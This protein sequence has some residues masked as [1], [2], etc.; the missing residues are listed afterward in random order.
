[1]TVRKFGF[2]VAGTPRWHGS[3]VP[4]Q[5]RTPGVQDF[6]RT[7]SGKNCNVD[8]N[9]LFCGKLPAHSE[10]GRQCLW[11]KTYGDQHPLLWILLL[12]RGIGVLFVYWRVNYQKIFSQLQV[13]ESFAYRFL[14]D[15]S[16][17][18]KQMVAGCK[19][20]VIL[21]SNIIAKCE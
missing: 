12:T 16:V 18:S 1:M 20:F 11:L 3:S 5:T 2:L 17:S 13:V 6:S 7:V 15:K 10:S 4:I 21:L 9:S 19:F 8:F 14:L